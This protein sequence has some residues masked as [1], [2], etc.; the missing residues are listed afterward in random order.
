MRSPLLVAILTAIGCAE[1][2]EGTACMPVE[3]AECPAPED[4][5]LADLSDTSYC[6]HEVIEMVSTETPEATPSL[7]TGTVECCYEVVEIDRSP[8]SECMV[9]RPYVE[10]GESVLPSHPFVGDRVTA[11]WIRLAAMEWAS[12]AAF[13]RLAMEI[14]RAHV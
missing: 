1:R 9:G 2:S 4:V 3:T 8:N 7:D 5:D 10:D 14:G 12:V 13:A 6:D 11:A